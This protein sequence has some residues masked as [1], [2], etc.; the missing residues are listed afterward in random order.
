MFT[1]YIKIGDWY[2]P[3]YTNYTYDGVDYIRFISY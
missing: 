1:Q 3:I 2:Y